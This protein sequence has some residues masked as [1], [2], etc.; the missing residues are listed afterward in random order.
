MA[1]LV[2]LAVQLAV[3]LADYLAAQVELSAPLP[4]ELSLKKPKL[5]C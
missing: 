4:V 2:E 5:A 3:L 1:T